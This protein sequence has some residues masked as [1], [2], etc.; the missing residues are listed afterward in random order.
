MIT[1]VVATIIKDG[2][3]LS[4][5][6]KTDHND[7]GF[8]G[9]KVDPGETDQEALVREVFEETGLT[10]TR[11]RMVDE[12]MDE[13][14]VLVKMFVV[15]E[16]EGEINTT[17]AGLVEWV[18]PVDLCSGGCSFRQY[19]FNL[20]GEKLYVELIYRNLHDQVVCVD[21][22]IGEVDDEDKKYISTSMTCED[23]GIKV[24]V[25]VSEHADVNREVCAEIMFLAINRT[26]ID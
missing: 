8:P 26:R 1:A 14:G 25:D 15:D 23:L 2:K 16:F 12:R 18:D 20:F 24:T 13:C 19:N 5:S 22:Y 17:E 6:R 7:R 4:V 21:E 10:I 3:V 11:S 9:G